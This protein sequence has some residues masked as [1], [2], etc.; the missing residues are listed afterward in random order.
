MPTWREQFREDNLL[1]LDLMRGPF[2]KLYG[3]AGLL[4]FAR[5]LLF[6]LEHCGDVF[7]CGL[8]LLKGAIW[9]VVWPMWWA[10]SATDFVLMH[11]LFGK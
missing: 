6:R 3:I 9:A 1:L 8:S 4:T 11:A 5:Q 7:G 2:G 10:M